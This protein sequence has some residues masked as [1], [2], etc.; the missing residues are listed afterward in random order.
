MTELCRRLVFFALAVILFSVSLGGSVKVNALS[1][2]EFQ[3][4][5]IMDDSIF[6]NGNAMNPSQIQAFLNAKVPVCDTWHAGSSGNNPPFT[7]LKDYRADTNA[8]SAE[9]GL[10]NGFAAGNKSAA[11]IIFEVGQSCGVSQKVLLVLLQKEQALVTDTWPWDIQYR[12]ATGFGCPD[13]APC[14]AQYYG[15]FNQVYMAARQF[16]MYARDSNLFNYRANRNNFILYNPNSACGGSNIFISTQATAGIYNYT[17]YQPNPAALN[18]LYGTGDSC[19]AYGNR[20]FWRLYND[21]FGQ[22]IGTPLVQ[23]T[24][25]TV[26]LVSN[27]VRYGIPS[28]EML[29]NYGLQYTKI[30]PASDAYIGSLSNGG[31]LGTLFAVGGDP[32]VYVADGNRKI[33]IPSAAL[34]TAWGFDCANNV[35]LLNY[36]VGGS[37]WDG[38]VLQPLMAYANTVYK[39][40]GGLRLPYLSAQAANEDGANLNQLNVMT[41][42]YNIGTA[43]GPP[44]IEN[45]SLVRFPASPTVYYYINHHFYPVPDGNTFN[46]WF[47]GNAK[48]NFDR[49]SSYANGPPSITGVLASLF[50]NSSGSTFLINNGSKADLTAR[51]SDWPSP[52]VASDLDGVV[53]GKP[54]YA[55]ASSASSY[56]TPDGAISLMAA[57]KRSIIPS[58]NDFNA[59]GYSLSNLINVNKE[60]LDSFQTGPYSIGEGSIFK[61]SNDPTS[62]YLKGP[63]NSLYYLTT[64]DQLWQ[65]H[66][67][68]IDPVLPASQLSSYTTPK[69]LNSLVNIVGTSTTTGV[70]D[71]SNRLWQFGNS[72]QQQWG[73]DPG[74]AVNITEG[75]PIY[76]G[77]GI[78]N[79]A[80]PSFVVYN[81]TVYYGSGGVKHPIATGDSYRNLG[82]NA[83]NTI[84]VTKDFIDASPTGSIL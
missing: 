64:Q 11:Q 55:T 14:D 40:Q 46:N 39:M 53:A 15:F 18:N 79:Q 36:D 71:A 33:G 62:I 38:G 27:G 82:G 76:G 50:K 37:L 26:F 24:T 28:N 9:A 84:Y 42:A 1:G 17:P 30:T 4:G 3:A 47:G 65:F 8:R 41:S 22:T 70:V 61:V 19:S 6:F 34:C 78:V 43:A 63:S 68:R 21:W 45:N 12:S 20:N 77:L 44:I 48:V 80:L 31:V 66:L 52:L 2:S 67:T 54:Q 74:P 10:C 60:T 81:G 13:T 51:A 69:A 73:I 72:Q 29:V 49:V 57:G 56:R 5:R 35:K 75:G 23:G 83:S 59:L 32:T 7:C 58:M 25:S 16:K